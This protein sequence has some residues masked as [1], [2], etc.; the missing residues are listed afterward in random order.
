MKTSPPPHPLERQHCLVFGW[1][2]GAGMRV[3]VLVSCGELVG[4]A[5]AEFEAEDRGGAG[6][7][8]GL[9]PVGH[10]DGHG[11]SCVVSGVPDFGWWGRVRARQ[12][13]V[14]A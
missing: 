12:G 13:V 1:R 6:D 2:R 5:A 11:L 3:G 9:D 8:E 4:C 14:V 10:R 7:V